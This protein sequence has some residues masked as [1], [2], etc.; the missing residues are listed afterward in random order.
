[1]R[2]TRPKAP[3][4]ASTANPQGGIAL[5]KLASGQADIQTSR[6]DKG[7]KAQEAQFQAKGHTTPN[8]ANGVTTKVTHGMASTLASKPTSDT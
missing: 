8:I 6:S 2:S 1:M 5:D 3:S 7:C 4:K